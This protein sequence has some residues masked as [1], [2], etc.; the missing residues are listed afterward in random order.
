LAHQKNWRTGIIMS[1]VVTGRGNKAAQPD[2]ER[3]A[4]KEKFAFLCELTR[5]N[6]VSHWV[7][8]NLVR[9]RGRARLVICEQLAS[10]FDL[11][12]MLHGYFSPS[13]ADVS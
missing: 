10:L 1:K 4:P 12:F 13:D 3:A 8:I 11:F 6:V 5:A 7:S 2:E 9:H